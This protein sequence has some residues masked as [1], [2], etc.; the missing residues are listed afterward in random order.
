S[1]RTSET[2]GCPSLVPNTATVT[3]TAQGTT[4]TDQIT[5]ETTLQCPPPEPGPGPQ[6]PRPPDPLVPPGPQP[7]D[8]SD[9]AHA[10]FILRQATAGCIRTRVPRVNFQGTRIARIRVYVNGQLR[11]RLTVES[12]Q[13]RLT[14]RVHLAPGRYRLS[15]RVTFDRGTGSPPVTLTRRI[16][17]C[18]VLAARPPF[19]G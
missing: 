7:P 10:G 4:V 14:P 2:I 1:R 8:S 17:I 12:L 3:G 15:V 19:T 18:G 16:R 6:P 11:R 9:A 5:I 13:R